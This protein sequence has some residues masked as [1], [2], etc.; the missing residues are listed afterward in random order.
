MLAF[1]RFWADLSLISWFS[2]IA[3]YNDHVFIKGNQLT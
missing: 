1:Q 2:D 3:E